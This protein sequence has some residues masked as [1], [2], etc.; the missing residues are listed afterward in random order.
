[1]I[2]RSMS[3]TYAACAALPRTLN[4]SF[5]ELPTPP[6][7]TL[8]WWFKRALLAL[9]AL[10]PAWVAASSHPQWDF[11][12]TRVMQ[13]S[14][15]ARA[16]AINLAINQFDYLDAAPGSTRWQTPRELV[17]HGMGSCQD[18]ALAKFWLLRGSG[19]RSDLVRLAFGRIAIGGQTQLHLVVLLWTDRG[20]PWVLDNLVNGMH[21]ASARPE[22][23]IDYTFDERSSTAPMGSNRSPSSRCAAG[24]ASGSASARS[25][26]ESG[27]ASAPL[28]D[29]RHQLKLLAHPLRHLRC[30]IDI[31]IRTGLQPVQT[32]VVEHRKRGREPA[33]IGTHALPE[34]R[35]AVALTEGAELDPV[36]CIGGRRLGERLRRWSGRIDPCDCHCAGSG[37]G[38]RRHGGAGRGRQL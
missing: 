36:G 8:A 13:H 25:R 5:S 28:D 9:L 1:M 10:L 38:R 20:E 35:C 29:D 14:G 6:L 21:R 27:P 32:R 16:A 26:S 7:S 31:R 37:R 30:L 23:Q 12:L 4:S 3:L 15:S 19:F 34:R 2:E 33:E 24:V 11:L 22:L 17:A 18:F